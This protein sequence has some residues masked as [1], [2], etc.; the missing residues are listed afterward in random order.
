MYYNSLH[1]CEPGNKV[2]KKVTLKKNGKQRH[3][4]VTRLNQKENMWILTSD[5]LLQM[6]EV[7]PR[8]DNTAR[9]LLNFCFILGLNILLSVLP[10]VTVEVTSCRG[11]FQI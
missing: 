9:Q 1:F 4:K 10:K 3:R 6:L 8:T 5:P 2:L 11:N 7:L